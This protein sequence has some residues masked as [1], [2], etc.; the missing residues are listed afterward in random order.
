MKNITSEVESSLDDINSIL[1]A[2]EE[3]LSE[4]EDS[5]YSNKGQKKDWKTWI[6]SQWPLGLYQVVQRMCNCSLRIRGGNE[7]GAEKIFEEIMAKI[8]QNL[9]SILN[10][11]EQETKWTQRKVEM[12][13]H[14]DTS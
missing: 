12:K 8:F 1:V 10:S 3:K 7:W 4:H 13:P 14:Q 5:F 2:A 6:E 9:M 11:Q